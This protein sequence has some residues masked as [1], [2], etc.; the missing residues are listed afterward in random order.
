MLYNTILLQK[1]LFTN[2]SQL[3]CVS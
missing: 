3:S 1:I 2:I